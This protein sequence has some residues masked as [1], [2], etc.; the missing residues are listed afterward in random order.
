MPRAHT[1]RGGRSDP[2][3]PTLYA[4]AS[5]PFPDISRQP[6]RG[7]PLGAPAKPGA[8]RRGC[9]AAGRMPEMS[10]RIERGQSAGLMPCGGGQ[11][12]TS[13]LDFPVTQRSP[14]AP[15]N[16]AVLRLAGALVRGPLW[17]LLPNT[18]H[19]GVPAPGSQGR[20]GPRRIEPQRP[21]AARSWPSGRA[22]ARH[23]RSRRLDAVEPVPVSSASIPRR[24]SRRTAGAGLRSPASTVCRTVAPLHPAEALQSPAIRTSHVGLS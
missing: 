22:Y 20:A 23:R 8:V 10:A 1:R 12:P 11:K 4:V 9:F 14:H 17:G 24:G 18:A 19:D 5:R 6:D 7:G 15:P 2:S 16:K 13:F 3:C 21:W